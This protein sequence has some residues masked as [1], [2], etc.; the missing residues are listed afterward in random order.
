[1][2][3]RM[4]FKAIGIVLMCTGIHYLPQFLGLLVLGCG[5]GF[6]FLP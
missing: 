6:T 3:A 4:G 1:M 2:D 5:M